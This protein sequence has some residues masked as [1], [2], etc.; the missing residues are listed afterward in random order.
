MVVLEIAAAASL[1]TR[2]QRSRRRAL[3]RILMRLEH[4]EAV[5]SDAGTDLRSLGQGHA[6]YLRRLQLGV[7]RITLLARAAGEMQIAMK[8]SQG[9]QDA[10]QSLLSGNVIT[11][12]LAEEQLQSVEYWKQGDASLATEDNL[13]SRR[14]LRFD[15]RVVS[16]MHRFWECAL[17][18]AIPYGGDTA[19]LADERTVM[20]SVIEYEGYHMMMTRIYRLL[21]QD[22]DGAEADRSIAEDW[23]RDVRDGS[24]LNRTAFMDSL[25]ELC[26]TVSVVAP[27]HTV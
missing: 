3:S 25:F 23:E 24:T 20:E 10:Q 5:S 9:V 18:S 16:S 13:R 27:P 26:D 4:S 7:S 6:Q 12:V 8:V 1:A 22:Y 17:R 14:R 19:A 11:N 2:L 21:L 15:A